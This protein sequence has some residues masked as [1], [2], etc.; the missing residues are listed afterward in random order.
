MRFLPG[1]TDKGIHGS[2][3][4]YPFLLSITQTV[5]EF[6]LLPSWQTAFSLRKIYSP[7]T[8]ITRFSGLIVRHVLAN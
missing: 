7:Y 1:N 2:M 3:R 8:W 4:M 5:S 6:P